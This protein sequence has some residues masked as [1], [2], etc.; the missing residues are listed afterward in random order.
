MADITIAELVEVLEKLRNA[1]VS[2]RNELSSTYPNLPLGD[3]RRVVARHIKAALSA[4][5]LATIHMDENLLNP[6]WWSHVGL[7]PDLH[8]D[9]ILDELDD[10]QRFITLGVVINPFSLF[11]S[12]LRRIGRAVDPAAC[13]NG[14]AEFKGIYEWL[15]A[16]LGRDGWTYGPGEAVEFLDLYR[17]RRN[18]LHNNGKFY[19]RSGTNTIVKWRQGKYEFVHGDEPAFT[20]WDFNALLIS[21]LIQLN[22]SLMVSPTIRALPPIQ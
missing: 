22:K 21:E 8:N 10:Y 2:A 11:E 6:S 1:A 16:R 19:S 4:A 20:D 12:G 3:P 14:T 7:T 9:V 17:H 15:L 13:S 18:T 5:Y